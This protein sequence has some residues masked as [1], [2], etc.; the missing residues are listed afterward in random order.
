MLTPYGGGIMTNAQSNPEFISRPAV[1][2]AL[3]EE[4]NRRAGEMSICRLAAQTGIFCKGFH[5]YS[6][7]ELKERYG[8][9]SKKNP[10]VPREELEQIADRWQLAR[11]EVVGA[12]T[13]CDVQQIEHDACGGWD[14]FG[15]DQLARFLLELTGRTVVVSH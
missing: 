3:R 2:A 8:W 4:L 12:R 11:Q 6:D 14:D 9:I 1:I 10:D 13:S 7:A 5:R 15:D